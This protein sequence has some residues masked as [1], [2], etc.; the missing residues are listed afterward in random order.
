MDSK[1]SEYMFSRMFVK[2]AD[3]NFGASPKHGFLGPE[4][5]QND[6]KERRKEIE[7][8]GEE[9][10]TTRPYVFILSTLEIQTPAYRCT[11]GTMYIPQTDRGLISKETVVLRP[12]GVETI[13]DN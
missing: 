11:Y 2:G 13:V 7:E 1:T 6:M 9:K 5:V 10:K 3:E 8:R 4:E 12:W